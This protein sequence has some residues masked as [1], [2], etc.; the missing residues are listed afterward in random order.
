M[1]QV[2]AY[3]SKDGRLHLTKQEAIA[4]DALVKLTNDFVLKDATRKVYGIA[5]EVIIA[6]IINNESALIEYFAST[7][8]K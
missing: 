2:T 6:E 4:H 7:H 3:K 8:K 5:K 1:E